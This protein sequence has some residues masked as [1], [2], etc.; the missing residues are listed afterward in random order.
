MANRS[1]LWALV[2]LLLV[3]IVQSKELTVCRSGCDSGKIQD[4]ID[5]ADP[6]DIITVQDGV[7]YE[8][9]IVNKS[10]TIRSQ[11]GA[12]NTV[13]D[14]SGEQ[15]DIV[16]VTADDVVLTGFSLMKLRNLKKLI[17]WQ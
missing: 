7:Y 12:A 6:G 3:G 11:N 2:I 14:G 4:A 10:L 1:L 16:K 5:R 8:D 15:A 17:C 13:I 9:V